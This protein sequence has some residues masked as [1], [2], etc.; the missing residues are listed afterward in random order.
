MEIVFGDGSFDL[1][2]GNKYTRILTKSNALFS[3]IVQEK[4]NFLGKATEMDGTFQ[5]K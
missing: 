3:S 1:N 4:Q 5:N 2:N